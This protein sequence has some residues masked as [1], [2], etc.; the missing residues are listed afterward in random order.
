MSLTMKSVIEKGKKF[1]LSLNPPKPN[2]MEKESEVI[3]GV[4]LGGEKKAFGIRS[5]LHQF[6]LSPTAE[7]VEGAP[8]TW[9]LLPPPPRQRAGVYACRFLSILGLLLLVGGAASIIYGYS[10]QR[11][12]VEASIMRIAIVQDDEGNFYIPQERFN[13]ILKDPMRNYKMIGFCVFAAGATLMALSLLVPACA[14]V[15]GTKKLAAFIS[16]DNTPNEP[17][18]RIYPTIPSKFKVVPTKI[19]PAHRISPTGPVPVMEEISKVQPNGKV[20]HSGSNEHLVETE[21][22]HVPFIH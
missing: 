15:A 7:E 21:D 14:H 11:E 18:I 6:Y 3:D 2:P 20:V 12:D 9:Y 17:P 8:G 5:Y 16:E 22:V 1:Y 19:A 10:Y 13:E 4:I